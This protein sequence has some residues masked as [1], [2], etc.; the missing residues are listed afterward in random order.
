MCDEQLADCVGDEDVE[1]RRLTCN[2]LVAVLSVIKTVPDVSKHLGE[3]SL[4]FPLLVAALSGALGLE[5]TFV[6]ARYLPDVPGVRGVSTTENTEG[7]EGG[8][9]VFIGEELFRFESHGAW[10]NHAARL[11]GGCDYPSKYTVCVDAKNRICLNGGHFS[12][13]RDEDAFPV[14]VYKARYEG[15]VDLRSIGGE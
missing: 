14:V 7:T 13:A 1:L 2:A 15:A 11:F 12:E 4:E 6:R 3:G 9:I 8:R 5:E 10:V